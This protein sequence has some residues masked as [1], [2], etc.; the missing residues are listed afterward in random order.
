MHDLRQRRGS[1]TW[2]IVI[3]Y[4]RCPACD[5][6]IE[7]REKYEFKSHHFEKKVSCPRCGK[8]FTVTKPKKKGFGPIFGHNENP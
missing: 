8:T 1:H 3:E 4:L 5:Y 6:V 7:N 2:D